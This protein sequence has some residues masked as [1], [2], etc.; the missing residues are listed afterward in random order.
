MF[1]FGLEYEAYDMSKDIYHTDS[2]GVLRTR[3]NTKGRK[4]FGR[5]G[6][7][8]HVVGVLT[9]PIWWKFF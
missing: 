7:S 5:V 3:Q 8:G 6:N 9:H 2:G 1:D 4:N